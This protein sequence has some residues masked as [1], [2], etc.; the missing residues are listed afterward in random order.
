MAVWHGMAWYAFQLASAGCPPRCCAG[1][2]KPSARFLKVT[3]PAVGG[4]LQYAA[5][6]C[7]VHT[8][9]DDA[10]WAACR[11]GS[12]LVLPESHLPCLCQDHKAQPYRPRL[13]GYTMPATTADCQQWAGTNSHS[14]N[15][16]TWRLK[17]SML[18][19]CRGASSGQ[20]SSRLTQA[21][22]SCLTGNLMPVPP[23]SAFRYT[24]EQSA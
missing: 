17:S 13:P 3:A 10:G 11:G 23:D 12:F 5:P 18:K 22:S 21:A 20:E 8:H 6:H 24:A 15:L 2:P 19:A 9:Q 4:S 7:R 14:A 16:Q 1:T